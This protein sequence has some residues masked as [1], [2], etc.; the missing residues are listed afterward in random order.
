MIARSAQ[1][2]LNITE[3]SG[4]ITIIMFY[5]AKKHKYLADSDRG[6]FEEL[7]NKT[8]EIITSTEITDEVLDMIGVPEEVVSN[9]NDNVVCL[10]QF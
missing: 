2:A 7:T 5:W 6:D 9:N 8:I 1:L 10:M 4:T 3:W